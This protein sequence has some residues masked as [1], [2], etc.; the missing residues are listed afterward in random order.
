MDIIAT[1]P[2][3]VYEVLTTRGRKL[4]ID[5]PAHLPNPSVIQEIREPIVKAY[6]LARMKTSV[7]ILRLI[8]EK[9]GQ[10]ERT[11]S[12]DTRRVMLHCEL[13]SRNPGRF[14]DKIKEH[15][16]RLRVDGLRTRWLSARKLV[17]LDLLVNR[18]SPSNAFSTIV[19][20]DRAD[21][22]DAS[23]RPNEGSNPPS[24]L[25]GGDSGGDWRENY[26]RGEVSALRKNVT[27]KMLRRD[28]LGNENCWEKQKEGKNG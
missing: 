4:S 14:N 5:N 17:K 25:S 2:S 15:H 28:I 16:A 6:V 8:L 19:H 11:E 18:R 1:S 22:V 26:C 27:A 3:V 21:G 24:A 12:L 10:M 9:R 20:K 7:D 13:R 23:W